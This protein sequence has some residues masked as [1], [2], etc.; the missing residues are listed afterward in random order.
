M[1]RD[2]LQ[3]LSEGGNIDQHNA[4]VAALA[5]DYPH[6]ITALASAHDLATYTCLVH[7]LGF[8]WEPG[9]VAVAHFHEH[10]FAGAEFAH[11]LLD[12]GK[13]QE[14]P[15]ADAANGDLVFY[16]DAN[17]GFKHVGI[18]RGGGRIESK[19]G[20][21]GLDE[22]PVFEVPAS[23]GDNARFFQALSYQEAIELFYDFAQEKGVQ[24]EVQEP[25]APV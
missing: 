9:Y 25:P 10:V 20:T 4:Q 7:A 21:Q 14:V 11:W 17:G 8:T 18:V 2:R 24:F 15:Q 1:L 22:H 6:S 23:Y 5:T 16:F 12:H 3:E 13:L 19:W